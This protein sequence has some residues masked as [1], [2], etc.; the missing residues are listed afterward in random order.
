MPT[1]QLPAPFQGDNET[2]ILSAVL[3]IHGMLTQKESDVID[4]D[5]AWDSLRGSGLKKFKPGTC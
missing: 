1:T 2:L 4:N 5:K 3:G